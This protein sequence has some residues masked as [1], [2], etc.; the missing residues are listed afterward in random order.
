MNNK[1][2]ITTHINADFDAIASLIAVKKLHP[3]AIVFFPGSQEKSAKDDFVKNVLDKVGVVKQKDIDFNKINKLILVDVRNP[4]RLDIPSDFFLKKDLDI[5]IYDHHPYQVG[6]LV[7]DNLIFRETG[8]TTTIITLILKEKGV[9]LNS[10]E[11]TIMLAGIY[12][13]TGSLTYES[14]TTDDYLACAFL[15]SQGGNL[16][17]VKNLLSRDISKEEIKLLNEML[18]SLK[19][20]S[21]Y[22]IDVGISTVFSE[23]YIKD[24]AVIVQ[25]IKDIENLPVIFGIGSLGDRI[26][27]SG[28][29]RLP[30]VD[31]AKVLSKFG[32]GGHAF[33]GSAVVK[34]L[35]TIQV[36][37]II[38][39]EL[40]EIIKKPK[41]A[42]DIMSMPV[43]FISPDT[44]IVEAEDILTRYNINMVPVCENIDGKIKLWG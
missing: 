9:N 8:S 31:V 23:D 5:I 39:S 34:D 35:T 44:T 14:T 7:T 26:I 24:F 11:A 4:K 3:S 37:E 17:I 32:G 13:D 38:L 25:K 27:I 43:K 1:E 22:G 12:E 30:E 33:A 21:I 20:Y 40:K 6:D 28:R 16:K 10:E 2:L 41:E 29:S 18:S 36:E 15:L 19:I 42:R